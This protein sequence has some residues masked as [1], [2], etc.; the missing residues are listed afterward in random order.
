MNVN[1]PHNGI[2]LRDMRPEDITVLA[3]VF[4]FDWT[5]RQD[6][7]E[8]W[9]RYYGEQQYNM[10]KI[11]IVER[12]DHPI[13]YGT[14]LYQSEYPHFKDAGIPEINDVWISSH[15]RG[16]GLGSILITHL[17]DNAKSRGFQVIGIG[18]GLYADYGAAQRL[19]VKLGYIPDGKGIT[20]NYLP[21]CPGE[22]YPV[23]DA[24]VLWLIKSL[25]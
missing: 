1:M 16:R 15:E 2:A 6:S 17:E 3:H 4:C 10:R 9:Q 19:Y 5:T 20:Y 18:V 8:K 14:L 13:G 12:K 24:L 25:N 21:V 23:D 22:K 11:Y 7:L